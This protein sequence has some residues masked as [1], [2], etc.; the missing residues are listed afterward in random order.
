M[1]QGGLGKPL[2][3][4]EPRGRPR[5]LSPTSSTAPP[6]GQQT[7]LERSR[8]PAPFSSP[9]GHRAAVFTAWPGPS[10]QGNPGRGFGQRGP[11]WTA[12][13]GTLPGPRG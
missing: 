7:D 4:G 13:A 6:S 1:G 2:R 3:T 5:V 10:R 12:W 11:E 8:A 9:T